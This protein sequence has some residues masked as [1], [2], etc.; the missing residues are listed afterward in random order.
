LKNFLRIDLKTGLER[1][2]LT[3]NFSGVREERG[4]QNRF[5]GF[6]NAGKPLKRFE[7]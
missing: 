4:I 3:T 7:D 1:F 6:W 2:S 5:N